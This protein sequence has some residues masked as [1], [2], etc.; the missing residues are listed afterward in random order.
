MKAP[1]KKHQNAT[2]T[3]LSAKSQMKSDSGG[4]R[5]AMQKKNWQKGKQTQNIHDN[6]HAKSTQS[7]NHSQAV[8]PT[9]NKR[10]MKKQKE[11][12]NQI[13]EKKTQKKDGKDTESGEK[14]DKS[15]EIKGNQ[16]S[17][18]HQQKVQETEDARNLK[19]TS[20]R[21]G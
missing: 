6:H 15:S 20:G 5:D 14:Q 21:F 3:S 16:H 18:R 13:S 12:L 17:E 9:N 4:G 8:D 2:S 1:Y 11:R 19:S 7:V 10:F